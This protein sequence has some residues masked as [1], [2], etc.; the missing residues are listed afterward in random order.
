MACITD[1]EMSAK[2]SGA[3]PSHVTED[4]M[5][6]W[7]K[8]VRAH[9]PPSKSTEDIRDLETRRPR[10]PRLTRGRGHGVHGRKRS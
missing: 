2:S 8:R 5:V 9:M 6:S 3:A 10:S 1:I 7:E 4:V